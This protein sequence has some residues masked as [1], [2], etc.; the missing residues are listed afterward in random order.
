MTLE[1]EIFEAIKSESDKLIQRHHDYHNSQHLEECRKRRRGNLSYEKEIKTPDYWELDRKFNPFY[2]AKNKKSI[3]KAIVLKLK[4]GTYTPNKPHTKKVQKLSGG[5]RQITIFQVPDAAISTWLYRKLLRKNK[6]RFSSFSYAYRNDKNVHFAIQD[7]AL[8]VSL[9]SRIFIAEFDFSDFFGSINHEYL[10]NQYRSNG[11]FTSEKDIQLINKFLPKTKGIFQGTS[12]SLFLANVACWVLDRSFELEGVKFARYADDTIIWSPSYSKISSAV[13]AIDRFSKATGV[14]INSK[15]SDGISLLCKKE[16]PSE[17]S[18]KKVA[19]D[20]LGY[21]IAP[22]AISIKKICINKIKK[23][24]SYILY[25]HLI[26]PLIGSNLAGITIPS[27]SNCD[28]DLLSCINEIRRYLYGD[29][30][31][32]TL[33]NYLIGRS[34]KISFKGIMSFY[35]LVN[36]EIQLRSLD[37]WLK[38]AI[39]ISVK[40]RGRLFSH[41]WKHDV[42]SNFPYTI[43][44]YSILADFKGQVI[45]GKTRQLQIP[46]FYMIFQAI[47]RGLTE[48]GIGGVANP[49]SLTYYSD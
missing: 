8:D 14:A 48:G 47:Q 23:Q 39:Y 27:I 2:V 1:D 13:E 37:G 21:S 24:I 30:S 17:F 15:K 10:K 22:E 40:K 16:T 29:V 43:T 4:D 49:E 36:D 19:F 28:P 18:S 46:S 34:N 11:F 20:F 5:T 33:N 32:Q 6:H 12:I 38:N 7:V 44:R 41:K 25:K 35:P 45:N 3:S 31:Q 9:S 42:L 26:Q